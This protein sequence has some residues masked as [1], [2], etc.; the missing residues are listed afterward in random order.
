MHRGLTHVDD[1]C[2]TFVSFLYTHD[3]LYKPEED[4]EEHRYPYCV[5]LGCIPPVVPPLPERTRLRVIQCFF[6][7]HEAISP[8]FVLI[9]TSPRVAD[10][11]HGEV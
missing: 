5:P 6:Q 4:G 10:R 2:P 1:M 7:S 3:A 9:N 11:E 8:V